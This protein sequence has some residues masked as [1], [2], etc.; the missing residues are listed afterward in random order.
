[1]KEDL[2]AEVEKKTTETG[3]LTVANL[4]MISDSCN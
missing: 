2:K 1:M 4:E 3:V